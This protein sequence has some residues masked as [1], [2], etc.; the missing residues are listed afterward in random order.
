MSDPV[1]FAFEDPARQ[2]FAAV[3][4]DGSYYHL[5]HPADPTDIR[6]R[7]WSRDGEVVL[8]PKVAAGQLV[9]ECPSGRVRGTCYVVEAAKVRLTVDFTPVAAAN[10]WEGAGASVEAARG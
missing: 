4:R 2:T 9:C 7:G 1:V 6:V 8:E 5:V 10:G 3:S